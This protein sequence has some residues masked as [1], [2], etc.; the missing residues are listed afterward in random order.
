MRWA[1]FC[2]LRWAEQRLGRPPTPPRGLWTSLYL[3]CCLWSPFLQCHQLC[4]LGTPPCFGLF[5]LQSLGES[6]G[7][8]SFLKASCCL[9]IPHPWG[10]G[11]G[12]GGQHPGA[13]LHPGPGPG[14]LRLECPGQW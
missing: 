7:P 14:I 5:W 12:W 1:F 2:P 9:Y 11:R 13:T 10:P 4:L 3:D 6:R 8:M